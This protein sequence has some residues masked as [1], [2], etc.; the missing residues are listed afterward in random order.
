MFWRHRESRGV[1]GC[2]R[3]DRF[4]RRALKGK[5]NQALGLV[6]ANKL[7]GASMHNFCIILQVNKVS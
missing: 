5:L 3:R 4:W 6:H 1:G 7:G 2:L